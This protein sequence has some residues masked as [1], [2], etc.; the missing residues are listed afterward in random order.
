[1]IAVFDTWVFSVIDLSMTKPSPY[2][3]LSE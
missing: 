2:I 3:G 1:L